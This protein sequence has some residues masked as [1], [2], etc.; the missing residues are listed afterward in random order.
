ME[1]RSNSK[2]WVLSLTIVEGLTFE[3]HPNNLVK[4]AVHAGRRQVRMPK[5]GRSL[6]IL[7]VPPKK[8]KTA[9]LQIRVEEDVG[10]QL[11]HYAEF[12]DASPS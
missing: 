5:G 10:Q 6:P 4:T 3:R 2:F 11:D 12:I 1:A 7:K 9:S 8:P